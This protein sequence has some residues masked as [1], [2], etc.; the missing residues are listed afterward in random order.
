MF[1]I[2]GYA[3][4]NTQVQTGKSNIYIYYFTRKLPATPDFAK[5]GAFHSGEIV[6]ALDNLPF[7]HRPWEPVDRDLAKLMS[8][9]WVNFI[10]NGDPNGDNLP[11]WPAYNKQEFKAMVFG[12][13][14]EAAA[15]PDKEAL[16]FIMKT[17]K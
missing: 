4:A 6:Y 1:G 10:K 5:Y 17:L 11:V 13:S 16:D 12:D 2:Q 7:L 15:L 9:Y 8:S 3:W 14:S